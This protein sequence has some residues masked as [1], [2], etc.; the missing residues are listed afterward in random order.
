[1]LSLLLFVATA[2]VFVVVSYVED[3]CNCSGGAINSSITGS[4]TI[5]AVVLLVLVVVLMVVLVL[6]VFVVGG[7]LVLWCRWFGCGC[8]C[9]RGGGVLSPLVAA[10]V[11]VLGV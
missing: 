5:V 3:W 9:G 1:M 6:V 8:C 4:S 2:A 10:A 11:A 7:A